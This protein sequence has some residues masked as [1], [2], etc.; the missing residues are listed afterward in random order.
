MNKNK[1]FFSYGLFKEGLRQ[2]RTL[3]LIGLITIL[4]LTMFVWMSCFP[5]NYD[6]ILDWDEVQLYG[7]QA[8]AALLMQYCIFSPF[9][10]L[11]LFGFLN[12]RDASDLYHAI[13]QSRECLH[14]SYFAGVMAWN[15][16]TTLSTLVLA[17]VLYGVTPCMAL[18][19]SEVFSF[20][21][22]MFAAQ[23]SVAAG[24]LLAMSVTGTRFTNT[25]V[26]LLVIFLPRL[27]LISF[28]NMLNTITVIVDIE[29]QF[30]FLNPSLNVAAG[31]PINIFRIFSNDAPLMDCMLNSAN[32]I[33]TL[34]L[35]FLLFGVALWLLHHRKSES[36]GKSSPNRI[37]QAVFRVALGFVLGLIPVAVILNAIL[38]GDIDNFDFILVILILVFFVALAYFLFELFTTKKAKNM[39]KAIPTFLLVLVLDGIFLGAVFGIGN[40]LLFYTPTADEIES[41]TLVQENRENY[42]SVHASEIPLTDAPSK[43]LLAKA[44]VNTVKKVED[45]QGYIHT[46]YIYGNYYADDLINET[47]S[48]EVCVEGNKGKQYRYLLIDKEDYDF[49]INVME[50]QEAYKQ[51][52]YQIPTPQTHDMTCN[53]SSLSFTQGQNIA[54]YNALVEDV[55]AM[56]FEQWYPKALSIDNAGGDSSIPD[57]S[58]TLEATLVEQGNPYYFHYPITKTLTPKAFD[59]IMGYLSQD[60]ETKLEDFR[61]QLDVLQKTKTAHQDYD[62]AVTVLHPVEQYFSNN[63]DWMFAV[64]DVLQHAKPYTPGTEDVVVEMWINEYTTFSSSSP[65]SVYFTVEYRFIEP[66]LQNSYRVFE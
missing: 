25:V 31:I 44:L 7:C 5:T 21:F 2:T 43:E 30:P 47:R 20:G 23:F 54:V 12:K 3:G 55:K 45:N 46:Y 42:F 10:V 4:V 18:N 53:V 65:E 6:E 1:K 39:L 37:V 13:P 35:G 33:Y 9:M 66:Y 48:I 14:I 61:N 17:V 49:I 26:S 11:G 52:F 57:R 8:V 32:G 40:S 58:F 60:A 41:V 22:N 19:F 36:A 15:A 38:E 28:V 56:P 63:Q 59:L 62:V 34:S 27:V 50:S 16:I 24:V 64:Q 29:K 51:T